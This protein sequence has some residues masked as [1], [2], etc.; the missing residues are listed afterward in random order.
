[1]RGS[2]TYVRPLRP[3]GTTF[4]RP[5]DAADRPEHRAAQRIRRTRG[6]R[7]DVASPRG[8]VARARVCGVR[9]RSRQWVRRVAGG[10][11]RARLDTGDVWHAP[12]RP[13]AVLY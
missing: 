13:L 12:A 4:T 8:G 10:I 5:D 9:C 2:I 11:P 1:M 3:T 6:C 7:E